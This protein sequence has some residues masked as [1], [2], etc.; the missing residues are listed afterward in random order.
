MRKFAV[1]TTVLMGALIGCKDH[2]NRSPIASAVDRLSGESESAVNAQSRKKPK[3]PK[4]H[5]GGTPAGDGSLLLR[6]YDDVIGLLG[7]PD[8]NIQL[9][10]GIRSEQSGGAPE[11]ASFL[12]IN[13]MDF[14]FGAMAITF[15]RQTS[16]LAE[17]LSDYQNG[18]LSF[19]IRLKRP[20][21]TGETIHIGVFENVSGTPSVR[22]TSALGF[23]QASQEWQHITIPLSAYNSQFTAVWSPFH[24]RFDGLQRA[25]SFD[26]DEIRWVR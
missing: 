26:L 18:K 23:S 2:A 17:D 11:G 20:L 22:L 1:V 16:N 21:A 14:P 9:S 8:I 24:L 6:L 5:H 19:Y 12:A 25:V 10:S 3:K 15:D 4:K 13:G 7:D